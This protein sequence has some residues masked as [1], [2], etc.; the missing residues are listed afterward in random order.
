MSR[1]DSRTEPPQGYAFPSNVGPPW[2]TP[3]GLPGSSTDRSPRAVPNHPGEPGGCGHPLLHHR[4]QASSRMAAW[5]LS[6]CVTRPN[7]VRLRY[8]SRVRLRQASSGESLHRPLARLP[9]E[10]VITGQ[11]PFSLQDQPGLSWH[12]IHHIAPFAMC[13]SR[14]DQP[15]NA[16]MANTATCAPPN[17]KPERARNV[18]AGQS[19]L[20]FPVFF[21]TSIFYLMDSKGHSRFVLR[22]SFFVSHPQR[23]RGGPLRPSRSGPNHGSADRNQHG[24]TI[25]VLPYAPNPR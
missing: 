17:L 4:W 14:A 25:K 13:A 20:P 22:I 18:G 2:A 6:V 11:A 15:L 23:R 19:S 3:P 7:R 1:S 5:P 24:S 12:S 8:G 16:H 10:W 21:N 9:V